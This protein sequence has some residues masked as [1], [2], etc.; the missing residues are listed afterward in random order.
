MPKRHPQPI[1]LAQLAR[2]GYLSDIDLNKAPR[3]QR[4]YAFDYIRLPDDE[5]APVFRRRDLA[6]SSNEAR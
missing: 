3:F 2:G 5:L 4:E 1:S 6:P